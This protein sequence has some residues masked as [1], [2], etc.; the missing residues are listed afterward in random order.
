MSH[1][2]RDLLVLFREGKLNDK[3][4]ELQVEQLNSLLHHVESTE[5]FCTAHEVYDLN[6]YKILTQPRQILQV[7]RMTETKPFVF[8]ANKN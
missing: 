3:D 4:L 1:P 2:N 8:V 7:I 5:C 6:R